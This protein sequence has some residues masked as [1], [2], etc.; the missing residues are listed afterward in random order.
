MIEINLV[1]GADRRKRRRK[2]KI[3]LPTGGLAAVPDLDRW[4]VAIGASWIIGPVLIAWLFLSVEASRGDL[5]AAIATA[6]EDS[7][8]YARIIS[9]NDALKARRD[10]IAEKLEIIQQIDAGRYI[11]PHVMDEISRALPE[12]AWL[13][14]LSQTQGGQQPAFQLEGRTGTTF[15]ITRYLNSLEASPFIRQVDI[16]S[17]QRIRLEEKVMYHFILEGRYE[18]PTSDLIETVPIFG[19]ESSARAGE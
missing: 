1:P 4:A 5:E 7:A 8:R 18:E 3:S 11:W 15:A 14:G 17:T 2:L 12:Y 16:V 19:V 9:T 6:Q 13:T 10:T